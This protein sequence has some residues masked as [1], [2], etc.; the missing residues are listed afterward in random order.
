M[1][2]Y[3]LDGMRTDRLLPGTA[4]LVLLFCSC[5]FP[6]DDQTGRLPEP[7]EVGRL[8]AR[9]IPESSGLV[10]S[11]AHAN[12]FWTLN[13]SG[14][15]AQLYAIKSTGE[16]LRIVGLVAENLDWEALTADEKGRLIAADIG[17]NHHV[18][19]EVQLYRCAEPDP[20]VRPT[21]PLAVETF[22]FMFPKK[23]G[24][25][26]VEAIVARAGY[27]Y[28]FTKE[29]NGTRAFRMPLPEKPPKSC[30]A[31]QPCGSTNL[32]NRVT[33]A[34]LSTDGRA[35]A[36][37]SLSKVMVIQW[38]KPLE[39]HTG[40]DGKPRLFEGKVRT[41]A[42]RLGQAEAIAWDGVDLLITTEQEKVFRIEK[43]R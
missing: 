43:A 32:L 34:S 9:H 25:C 41:R 13:D 14:N 8:P 15:P 22:R 23:P 40:A 21:A 3:T 6:A 27:G 19:P 18:R 11:P 39:E 24:P 37:L 31:L 36:I 4:L 5:T 42:I 33:G 16:L 38:P 35:L 1:R 29:R 7:K 28:I 12:V 17:D 2:L 26:D 20:R 10:K 30:V